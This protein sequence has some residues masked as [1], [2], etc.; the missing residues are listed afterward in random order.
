MSV[1]T[2][3][4][5]FRLVALAVWGIV[6]FGTTHAVDA[7]AVDT[8]CIRGKL[9]G[10]AS[11]YNPNLPG[12]RT[13]GQALA[14][15]GRY[16]PN[17]YE[18]ALQ[19]D[20][21]RRYGCGYGSGKV[22]D[23][24]VEGPT[25]RSM[26]V[27]INDNGPLVPGRVI[28]LNEKSMRYLSNGQYGNNSGVLRGVT[29]TVLCGT[30]GGFSGP[31]DAKDAAEWNARTFN[32]PAST[33]PGGG[34]FSGGGST[35]LDPR[36]TSGFNMGGAGAPSSGQ[37]APGSSGGQGGGTSAGTVGNAPI[38]NP[39][40]PVST[41]INPGMGGALPNA[42]PATP[43]TVNASSTIMGTPALGIAAK[44]RSGGSVIAWSSLNM[45]A[46]SCSVILASG[47]VISKESGG[48]KYVGA[49]T[50]GSTVRLA[51]ISRGQAHSSSATVAP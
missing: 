24:V 11:T 21:A 18:A 29:V 30:M 4:V 51:C 10:D 16:N 49:L 9:R 22:C 34:L 23:A 5:R 32:I 50:S 19:L 8:S 25:G 43:A 6:F 13:G 40:R 44:A 48:S 17:A 35:G 36:G 41:L 47:E 26:V 12:W 28:D 38:S 2:R 7:Q 37:P 3:I 27:R 15:G 42:T 14:T 20:W 45:D 46:G 31:L 1:N 39:P 33:N